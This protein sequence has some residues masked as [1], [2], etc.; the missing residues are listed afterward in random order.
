[1]NLLFFS[2]GLLL[3]DDVDPDPVQTT[4]EDTSGSSSPHPTVDT[5]P[6]GEGGGS[7]SEETSSTAPPD[8]EADEADDDDDDLLDM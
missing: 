1:M 6:E 8:R 7:S 4:G 3:E 5:P 2:Q